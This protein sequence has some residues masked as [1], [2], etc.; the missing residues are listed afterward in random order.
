MNYV[1]KTGR[2]IIGQARE[3]LVRDAAGAPQSFL[4]LIT[5]LSEQKKLEAQFLR[6]QRLEALG[7]LAGG[8]AHD[9]N[10][11]LA[12][13]L[14][15]AP[16]LRYV[17]TPAETEAT[18][19]AIESSAQRA[20]EVVRQLLTFSRGQGGQRMALHVKHLLRDLRSFIRETFPKNITFTISEAPDLW[21]MVVD[22][23]QLH[24][25]LLNLCINARDAM[26]EGGTLAVTAANFQADGHFASMTTG[27]R[28]VAYVLLQVSDTGTGIQPD[29]LEQIFD[30]FFTTKEAGRGTG[31]GLATVQ[32]VVASH[33]GFVRVR[34]IVGQGTT[35]DVYLPA[36]P[37]AVAPPKPTRVAPSL[38]GQGQLIL[39]VDD[40]ENIRK[41]T[42]ETLVRHG[43]RVETAQD[44]VEAV[45]VFAR[46]QREIKAVITDLM[47]PGMDGLG[48]AKV[49]ARM[50]PTVPVVLSTAAGNDP[51]QSEKVTALGGLGVGIMLTKPY[52][53]DELL[54]ALH[55]VLP[56]TD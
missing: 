45:E 38:T 6:A 15:G 2:E 46:R 49:L 4:L 11:N 23:T 48:L 32:R 3:T 42:Q 51:K 25:V 40:E 5:D 41:I 1:S 56:R 7:T 33:G 12:P 24:Q 47:M 39:V 22:A 43:Y 17:Q 30:P 44:G 54:Q 16:L 28:P 36:S 50:A 14:M 52:T 13:I 37:E 29:H 10:N 35:F 18:L 31:L 8:I 20:S 53:T 26:P 21:S 27:A 9:L 19:N 55:A 34:S